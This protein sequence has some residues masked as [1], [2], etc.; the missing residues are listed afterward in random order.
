MWGGAR[1]ARK[2]VWICVIYEWRRE[3][4]G[5]ELVLCVGRSAPEKEQ[6]DQ[7]MQYAFEEWKVC[8]SIARTWAAAKQA[9]CIITISS[10][11]GQRFICRILI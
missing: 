5:C 6:L 8:V 3:S 9:E 11:C 7:E 10:L 4:P 2:S 1:V